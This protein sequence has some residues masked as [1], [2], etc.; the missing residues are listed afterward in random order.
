M[1]RQWAYDCI[2]A[3]DLRKKALGKAVAKYGKGE[4]MAEL[5]LLRTKYEGNSRYIF[6]VFHYPRPEF[7]AVIIQSIEL[8]KLAEGFCCPKGMCK[9]G[10]ALRSNDPA[11]MSS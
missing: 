6:Y 1:V 9:A 2:L 4:T 11:R 7:R 10:S 3:D 5:S 8:T